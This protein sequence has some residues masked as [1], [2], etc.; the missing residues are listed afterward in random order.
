METSIAKIEMKVRNFIPV[1]NMMPSPSV[2]NA[3]F[4]KAGNLFR[5]GIEAIN[6]CL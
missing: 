4:S 2:N 3:N 5:S 6:T 1:W